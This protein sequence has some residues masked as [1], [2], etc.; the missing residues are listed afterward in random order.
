MKSVR[1][2]DPVA[3]E[4]LAA[5]GDDVVCAV[6][7]EEDMAAEI[8][9]IDALLEEADRDLACDERAESVRISRVATDQVRARRARRRADREVL[10][11]LPTRLSGVELPGEAA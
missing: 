2:T 5:L 1:I 3:S 4:A 11:A 9:R 7:R 10:R 8:A 6:Q